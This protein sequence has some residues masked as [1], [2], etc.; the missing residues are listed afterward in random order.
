MVSISYKKCSFTFM[1]KNIFLKNNSKR[2]NKIS[3]GNGIC[4]R[5]SRSLTS[6]LALPPQ[7]RDWLELNRKGREQVLLCRLPG[8]LGAATQRSRFQS[9]QRNSM[10]T[11]RTGLAL[12]RGKEALPC[13]SAFLSVVDPFQP[14][15][16]SSNP[17]CALRIPGLPFLPGS[18]PKSPQPKAGGQ[19][20]SP[21]LVAR[22][23]VSSQTEKQLDVNRRESAPTHTAPW[24]PHNH[25]QAFFEGGRQFRFGN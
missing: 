8:L 17:I 14:L 6:A 20:A 10:Q 16:I 25:G 2:Q 19:N 7:S 22:P 9:F 12:P 18:A 13:A 11:T 4:A 21:V 15:Q 3:I 24:G 23:R 1:R 5:T